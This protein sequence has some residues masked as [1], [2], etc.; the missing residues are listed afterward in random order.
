VTKDPTEKAKG[1]GYGNIYTPH[2][3]SMIIHVQRESGL[4]NRTIVLSQ[5]KVRLLRRGAYA[6]GA[7]LT[8]IL[9]SWFY[10]ATQAARV[11]FLTR[12]LQNLQHD[13]SR[14]DTLQAALTELEG[15][16]Q[17]VQHMLGASPP[18]ASPAKTTDSTIATVPDHWPLP[19]AGTILGDSTGNSGHGIDIAAPPGSP[20]R[21]A[22][23]GIV[24]EVKND[25]QYG[26][27]VRI[28]HRD[29]YESVYANTSD[30]RVTAGTKVTPETIIALSG[31]ALRG[32]PPHLHFE[33]RKGGADVNPVSL[34]KQGPAHGDLQQ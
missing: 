20:V 34:M 2:A 1:S 4:A 11:P 30:V 18:P 21:A 31:G 28:T 25:P 7:L 22:G 29:G 17:Q 33:V 12:R 6:L 27:L 8:V 14:L 3:G 24:V 13:V 16:F 26:Q 5:R 19:A 32:L 23:A 9:L 10:L 15:R